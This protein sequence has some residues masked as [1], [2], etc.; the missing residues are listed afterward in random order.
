MIAH[1]LKLAVVALLCGLACL[2]AI[3]TVSATA[4]PPF[5]GVGTEVGSLG[6]PVGVG[7][8]QES[9][10]LYVGESFNQSV[11]KFNGSGSFLFEWGWG[12]INEVEEPQVCIT[13]GRCKQ[14]LSGA[15]AGEFASSC[16]PNGVAVDNS[17]SGH[18]DVYVEDYCNHRVQKFSP[19]GEFLLMFGGRVNASTGGDLCLAG[20]RCTGGTEGN[21]DGEFAWSYDDSIIAAGPGGA[22]YVGDEARIQVFNATGTW[23]ENISLAG[24]SLTGKVTALAVNSAGDVFV[25]DEGV[26]GVHEF[27]PDGI[28]ESTRL[29]PGGETVEALA[30]DGSSDLFVAESDSGFHVLEYGPSG[31]ELESFG[32]D[33][34]GRATGIAIRTRSMSFMQ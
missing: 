3:G 31:K 32:A 33:T 17:P 7:I 34:A 13:A 20:E 14:G 8:D 9:G 5:G 27:E 26:P 16:G 29:D 18:K 21:G 25:K 24:L 11:S 22:V 28:E 15:G 23:R 12:V 30:I 10:D 19:Y 6:G 4:T 2:C 1:R